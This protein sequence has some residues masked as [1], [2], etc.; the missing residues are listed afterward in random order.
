MVLK[1][2]KKILFI[3]LAV[4]I[5]IMSSY[6]M[7]IKL[8]TPPGLS[9]DKN[10]NAPGHWK[11]N[12]V[13]DSQNDFINEIHNNILIRLELNEVF[14]SGFIEPLEETLP[15]IAIITWSIPVLAGKPVIVNAGES[16]DPDGGEIILIEWDINGDRIFDN[17]FNNIDQ[18]F[19]VYDDPGEF[20]IG[21]RVTDDEGQITE[22]YETIIV[23]T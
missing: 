21:L 4:S 3:I 7:A 11:K 5:L 14:P 8:D 12:T 16:Y 10:E 20:L 17:M 19:P 2:R 23:E 22:L 6:A 1:M 9:K 15:P 18:I 13:F